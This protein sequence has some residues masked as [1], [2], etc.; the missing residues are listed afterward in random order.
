MASDTVDNVRSVVLENEGEGG[1]G[2]PD[3]RVRHGYGNTRSD[4]VTGTHGYGY[5][6]GIWHTAAY[7]VPVPRCDG[8]FTGIL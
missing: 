5:G 3:N 6:I 4:R 8:Y 2:I 1:F 7:R